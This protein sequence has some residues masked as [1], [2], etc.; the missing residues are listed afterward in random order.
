MS[1]AA[2]APG[3]GAHRSHR[4]LVHRAGRLAHGAIVEGAVE[5]AVQRD[6][7]TDGGPDRPAP[8]E[9]LEPQSGTGRAAGREAQ[10]RE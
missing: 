2:F 7:P 5:T 8:S 1:T 9:Q 3:G 4:Q 10:A 6:G